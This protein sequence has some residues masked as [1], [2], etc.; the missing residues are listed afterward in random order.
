MLQV[1][2]RLKALAEIYTTH[3]FA[4]LRKLNF[5]SKN[6]PTETPQPRGRLLLREG[7]RAEGHVVR[8]VVPVDGDPRV[9]DRGGAQ[10]LRKGAACKRIGT[11]AK[12]SQL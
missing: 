7:L 4:Q 6:F 1:N 2:M 3:F 5:W 12:I 11:S 8:A 9:E 10:D